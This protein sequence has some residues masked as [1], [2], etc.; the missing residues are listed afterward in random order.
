MKQKLL[1]LFFVLTCLIGVSMA[2]NRQV[3]GK[4]TS[5]TDGSPIAGA[6]ISVVGGSSATQSDGSGNYSL[7]VPQGSTLNF[8]YIGYAS[9]RINVGS[10]STINVVLISEDNSLEEVVVTAM[11]ITRERRALATAT[12]EI[13]SDILTQ[14]SNSN[15]ATAIQ[16]KVSG[17]EVSLSSG[18]PGASAKI[19]IRGSRS[20][21]ADNTYTQASG[22]QPGK[23][24]VPQRAAAGLDPWATPQAYNN[25]KE[26]FDIG[27]TYN[28][29]LNLIQGLDKGHYA[30][31]LGATNAK[32]IVPSTGMDRYNAK[33]AAQ[34]N[35]S[36]K[37][38][39][40]F[41]GN[42]INSNISKQTGAND[43]IMATV[44]PAPPSYDLK[45][46]PN[47]V[48]GNPYSQNNYRGGSFDQPY[49]GTEHNRFT[50]GT[51]RFFGNSF[52]QY[53]TQFSENQKLTLRYQLGVD[54][55]TSNF[56][57]L[58]G[59][60]KAGV[61]RGQVENYHYSVT[62]LN[63]LATARYDWKINE[64]LTFDMMLGNEIVDRHRRTDYAFGSNFNFSGW[65]H[66]N[67]ATTYTAEQTLRQNRTFGLFGNIN[68]GYKNMLYLNVTGRNDVVSNMPRDNRSFFYPSVSTSF[69]FTELEGLKSDVLSFGKLRA[70][71]AE[72][73]Q[74][75]NYYDSYYSIPTYG[76]GFS[77]GTP[78]IY[79]IGGTVSFTPN[80]VLYDP[81]LRPQNTKAYEIGTDLT[82]LNGLFDLTYTFSRQDVKDQIFEVP[83]GG[84]SGF[85]SLVTNGGRVHTNAHEVTLNVSPYRDGD[86][87]WNFALNFTKIDNYVDE[88]ADGVE[89]IFLGGFVEPQIR[90]GMGEKFPVIYGNS[91]LRNE[92]GQ[93]VVD[94]NGLPQQGEQ[95]VIGRVSPDFLLGFNTRLEYK[96]VRLSAVLDWKNGG[97]M[98]HGT[99]G[100]LD[101]YGASQKSADF[102]S[103]DPF[104]F[105]REAVKE[106][107]PGVYEKN[108]ILIDPSD[109][110]AYFNRLNGISESSVFGTS[111]V[112][113]REISLG[114]PV[115][116]NTK[117]SVDLNAFARNLILWSELKG[118][119]PEASQGNTNMS[120]AFERF[121]LPGTSSYGFGL[122]IKF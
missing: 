99:G 40:G 110:F 63:S 22:K 68:L 19:T 75:G 21:T 112:K 100:I 17:V 38:T 102:R 76:G 36:E 8:S 104:L 96:K 51:Q 49:W 5:S 50:E 116:T 72:V 29:S 114:Y 25:A 98:L 14:A 20:F 81:A 86:F 85:S 111:F 117:F 92:A 97:Q 4:V 56:T 67:N 55:Y 1:S 80:S 60:G 16:G 24:Y 109:A 120:G 28:N 44:F 7:S 101:Y 74:A 31:S 84:S 89:S 18:M 52:A 62:E 122:N 119:D 15:L 43:G 107:S 87:R 41:T 66:I 115:Y 26:F 83:L 30:L 42:Y 11:G 13:K 54:S 3:S 93:I 59:Y 77:S 48:A 118:Y 70:S 35:P 10:Q 73:G 46:I 33:L 88:L 69:I 9:Q 103:G 53:V 39:T 37:W 47:H 27:T 65:N 79:P 108:D 105:D 61:T 64:D 32:G 45:G 2:Q 82:F 23:Y 90:A 57:D 94:A 6:S 58:W 95:Q 106:V 91:F 71:Y 113:L 34:I 12:Q 78:I 121:S